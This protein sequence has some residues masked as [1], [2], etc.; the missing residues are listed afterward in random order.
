[1]TYAQSKVTKTR[2]GII[3]EIKSFPID[4]SVI[5]AYNN[6][7]IEGGIKIPKVPDAAIRP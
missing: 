2:P 5:E 6:I 4:T 7:G 1:M 3:P